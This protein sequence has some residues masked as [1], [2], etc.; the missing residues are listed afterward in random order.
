MVCSWIMQKFMVD[1]IDIIIESN[2]VEVI[3]RLVFVDRI[4]IR[5]NEFFYHF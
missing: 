4:P 1:I 3:N 5:N 2:L